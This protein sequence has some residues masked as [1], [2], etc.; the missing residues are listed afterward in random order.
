ME[1]NPALG[2]DYCSRM[3]AGNIEAAEEL[4]TTSE[5][6]AERAALGQTIP[7]SAGWAAEAFASFPGFVVILALAGLLMGSEFDSN[8]SRNLLLA[9]PRMGRHILVKSMV[10]WLVVVLQ[11]LTAGLIVLA[12]NLAI[13]RQQHNLSDFYPAPGDDLFRVALLVGGAV[14][15]TGLAS[16]GAVTLSA[17]VRS[18]MGTLF[19]G[20]AAIGV[21]ALGAGTKDV[22][23]WLPGGVL[24]DT[25][26]FQAAFAVWNVVWGP[27]SGSD[28]P[29]VVRCLPTLALLGTGLALGV[30]AA[31]HRSATA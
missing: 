4:F 17:C 19:W 6:T 16:V 24:A 8:T 11:M 7:G 9:E 31:Q 29:L 26:D 23:A 1:L 28:I 20:G 25:M 15:V 5:Y 30:R 13:G 27:A 10:V 22:W 12:F 2:R 21:L 14:L 3:L 18:R